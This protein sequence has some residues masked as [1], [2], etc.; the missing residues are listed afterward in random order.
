[1]FGGPARSPA[2]TYSS[3]GAAPNRQ[4]RPHLPGRFFAGNLRPTMGSPTHSCVA[5][6]NSGSTPSDKGHRGVPGDD[7]PVLVEVEVVG[8][9][10]ASDAVI[11]EQPDLNG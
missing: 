4:R 10:G 9:G 1:P 3:T 5:W 11:H 8:R 7:G 2:S 6:R